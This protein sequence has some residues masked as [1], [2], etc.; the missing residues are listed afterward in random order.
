LSLKI[1]K[2]GDKVSV[3]FDGTDWYDGTV[4]HIVK[5][6]QTVKYDNGDIDRHRL[7]PK[8]ENKTWKLI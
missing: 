2:V 4:S 5:G 3:L 8:G 7:L 1:L 6:I